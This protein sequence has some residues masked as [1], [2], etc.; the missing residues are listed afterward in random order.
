MRAILTWFGGDEWIKLVCGYHHY[1]VERIKSDIPS[2]GRQWRPQRP[3]MPPGAG[4][5][6]LIHKEYKE[7]LLRLLELC[8]CTVQDDARQPDLL[9]LSAES[10]EFLGGAW[11]SW[12]P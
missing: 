3:D 1:L 4:K 8:D 6:W 2:N 12:R 10:E 11:D 9:P 7:H 5:F